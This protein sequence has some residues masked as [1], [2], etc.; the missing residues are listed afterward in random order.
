M[1]S[2]YLLVR[3]R[4]QGVGFRYTAWELA[5]MAGLAGW[6][7][8]REDGTVEAEVEGEREAVERFVLALKDACPAA[9]VDG[10]ERKAI[11]PRGRKDF[12]IR[13]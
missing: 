12:E 1:T 5:H 10:I 8:N 6:V 13:G 3:G 4:V 2:L 9:R 11:P 7:R